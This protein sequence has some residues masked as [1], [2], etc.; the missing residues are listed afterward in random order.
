MPDGSGRIIGTCDT[1]QKIKHRRHR[2][3]GL[4]Q[5]I[6]IPEKPFDVV[7]MDFIMDLPE[8]TRILTK[9]KRRNSSSN[10]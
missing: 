9:S 6:P 8:S 5:A 1:C 4:L 3:Y 10:T 7:S 2:P